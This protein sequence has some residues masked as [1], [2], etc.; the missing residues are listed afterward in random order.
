M[1]ETG[2]TSYC[3]S[4]QPTT[5]KRLYCW[6]WQRRCSRCFAVCIM[7][8]Q[9][10]F[11]LDRGLDRVECLT[12][13]NH[14]SYLF[15]HA[16]FWINVICAHELDLN[17]RKLMVLLVFKFLKQRCKTR[18]ESYLENVC[19][20]WASVF[21]ELQDDNSTMHGISLSKIVDEVAALWWLFCAYFS[22]RRRDQSWR[23]EEKFAGDPRSA[24]SAYFFVTVAQCWWEWH[25]RACDTGSLRKR[26]APY[27]HG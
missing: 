23:R 18:F 9:S 11:G 16:Y 20:L 7:E 22:Q 4:I 8:F 2:T 24:P 10:G 27:N 15:A 6:C 26:H 21:S 1:L 13:H 14:F 19:A 25:P 12:H 17:G 5:H 3:D